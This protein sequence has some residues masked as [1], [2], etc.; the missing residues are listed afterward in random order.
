MKLNLGSG[1]EKMEGWVNLD[2]APEVNPDTLFN[3][4]ELKLR[5]EWLATSPIGG[6]RPRLPFDDNTFD[7]MLMSHLLEHLPNPLAVMEELWR[8]AK[9]GCLLTCRL[10]YGGSDSAFEDPQHCRQYFLQSFEYFSQPCYWRADYGYRGDWKTKARNLLINKHEFPDSLDLKELM[11]MVNTMRN[12]VLEFYVELE[13]VKPPRE[14][15]RELAEG[16]PVNFCFIDAIKPDIR[17]I[18]RGG[19]A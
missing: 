10:P 19:T 3:L 18:Q 11:F 4:N 6:I 7:E 12:I 2:C 5:H 17:V 14:P 1:R 16:S 15:K 8:V 9:P 13:A